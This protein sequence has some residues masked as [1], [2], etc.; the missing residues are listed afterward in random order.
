MI[1]LVAIV[2]ALT[3]LPSPWGVVA[4]IGAA[5]VEIVEVTVFLWW[6]RRRRP[7]VGVET[8]MG[9]Q[10]TVALACRPRGQVRIAGELWAAHCAAGADSGEPVEVVGVDA[11]GLTLEVVPV[12]P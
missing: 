1:L 7:A 5:L 6:S 10:A 12:A 4:V 3:V 9:R 2:L 8:M 11:D